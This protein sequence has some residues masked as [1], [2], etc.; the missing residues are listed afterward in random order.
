M[1]QTPPPKLFNCPVNELNVTRV[2]PPWNIYVARFYPGLEGVTGSGRTGNTPRRPPHLSCTSG[3]MKMRDYVGK[4]VTSAKRVISTTP[5]L[6]SPPTCKQSGHTAPSYKKFVC[7]FVGWFVCFCS[8]SCTN[9]HNS[10]QE[11]GYYP[12]TSIPPS[13]L[14]LWTGP[15]LQHHH[16]RGRWW[17]AVGLCY[18][19][20]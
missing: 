8:S 16:N 12:T 18:L 3:Q 9:L 15:S 14:L 11:N 5:Y 20:L 19:R 1:I 10:H 4:R 6:V 7:L 13:W 2:T 17:S